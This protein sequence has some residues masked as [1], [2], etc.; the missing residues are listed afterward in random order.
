MIFHMLRPKCDQGPAGYNLYRENNGILL[1][2]DIT[3]Q[4][5]PNSGWNL[6][7]FIL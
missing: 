3:H 1:Q 6:Q 5:L 2:N 7:T 4:N